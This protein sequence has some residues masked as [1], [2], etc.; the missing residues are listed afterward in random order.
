[1]VT[2]NTNIKFYNE[3]A[4]LILEIQ[5]GDKLIKVDVT[6]VV[7]PLVEEINN[8]QGEMFENIELLAIY[9]ALNN[10]NKGE[11]I[12]TYDDKTLNISELKEKVKTKGLKLLKKGE[13]KL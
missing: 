3:L 6:D 1:M 13:V 7:L 5:E 12:I 9:E 11:T 4:T 10:F 2:E 8:F